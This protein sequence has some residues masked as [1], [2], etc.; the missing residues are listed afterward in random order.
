MQMARKMLMSPAEISSVERI[1]PRGMPTTIPQK[2]MR[3]MPLPMPLS[4]ICSPSHIMSTEPVQKVIMVTRRK[5]QPGFRTT[6]SPEG[7]DMFSSP[8]P[9]PRPWIR[10]ITTVR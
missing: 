1:M 4:V 5:D 2:M 10:V 3:E 9:M 8:I 6:G 7:L